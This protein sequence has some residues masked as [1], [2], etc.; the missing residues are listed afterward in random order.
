MGKIRHIAIQV[1]DLE[2]AAAFYEGVFELERVNQ[3]E[4]PSG[5]AISISAGTMNL[6]LLHFP[7]GTQG[8]KGGRIG[9]ACTTSALWSRT[10]NRPKKDR[11]F[12]RSILPG[13]CRAIPASTPK[14]NSRTSTASCSTFRSMIGVKPKRADAY[15]RDQRADH[16][17][18][19]GRPKREH[20][21]RGHDG[22]RTR[23]AYRCAKERKAAHR[24]SLRLDRPLRPR[25]PVARTLHPSLGSGRPP[26]LCRRS[27][28]HRS[29]QGLERAD[30]ER[31]ARR[32][33]RA[34][35]ALG[36][37]PRSGTLPRSSRTSRFGGCWGTSST[38][39]RSTP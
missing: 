9:P 4:R 24:P 33:A 17:T 13:S 25:R 16:P 1:P 6:T 26:N 11:G 28:R 8:S 7:E 37:T 3:V 19:D 36:S 2:K 14:R 27:R 31:E 38:M 18:G 35:R 21:L 20:Q 12:R 39:V 5:N 15:R 22:Q 29:A 34:M 30:D 23:G 32:S 10:R